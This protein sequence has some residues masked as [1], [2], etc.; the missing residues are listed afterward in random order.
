MVDTIETDETEYKHGNT[1]VEGTLSASRRSVH[2]WEFLLE[3]LMDDSFISMIEWTDEINGEFK[4]KNSEAVA[5]KWG[6]RKQK[7]GMN[8]DKLS[9]ALRYYYSKDII[10]KVSGRR[11]V[12]K[13][14]PSTEMH[15]AVDSIKACMVRQGRRNVSTG[16]FPNQQ[17]LAQIRSRTIRNNPDMKGYIHYQPLRQGSVSPPHKQS[18]DSFNSS[19][20]LSPRRES[21]DVFNSRDTNEVFVEDKMDNPNSHKDLMSRNVYS[22]NGFHE[23]QNKQS[24]PRFYSDI[25][26][27]LH[28]NKR[29]IIQY[30]SNYGSSVDERSY[31]TL[32]KG[33]FDSNNDLTMRLHSRSGER[34]VSPEHY[35]FHSRDQLLK[36]YEGVRRNVSL[37]CETKVKNSS[38]DQCDSYSNNRKRPH[39]SHEYVIQ[40]NQQTLYERR[41]IPSLD[42]DIETKPKPVN[43]TNEYIDLNAHS[44][45]YA[46]SPLIKPAIIK[47]SEALGSLSDAKLESEQNKKYYSPGLTKCEGRYFTFPEK[48]CL[49][50]EHKS[51]SHSCSPPRVSPDPSTYQP[52]PGYVLRKYVSLVDVWTQT[53]QTTEVCTSSVITSRKELLKAS[54]TNFRNGLLSSSEGEKT[55]QSKLENIENDIS[56]TQKT[57]DFFSIESLNADSSPAVNGDKTHDD[58]VQ[59]CNCGCMDIQNKVHFQNGSSVV[60][61]HEIY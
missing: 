49:R 30:N 5:K 14:I 38:D 24:R 2:L 59:S 23:E 6:E 37:P 61:K 58:I 47:L 60:Y 45:F 18:R 53:T 43:S 13:F 44:K 16:P 48:D 34:D 46:S 12:Y 50:S 3:L 10:Q 19:S 57:K 7:E 11:F 32:I 56:A 15:T 41:K 17:A 20:P 52:P 21:N 36:D 1:E 31:N 39:I 9:R 40:T 26:H 55:I 54:N 51:L 29:R 42:I 22:R 25:E 4:L 27:A 28:D 33:A 8:Y 35:A